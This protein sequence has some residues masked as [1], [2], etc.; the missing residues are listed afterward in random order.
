EGESLMNL[1]AAIFKHTPPPPH[2][3]NPAVSAELSRLTMRLLGKKPGDRPASAAEVRDELRRLRPEADDPTLVARTPA[4]APAPAPV[5]RPPRRRGLVA[6][7]A[8]LLILLPLGYFYGGTVM[9]IVTNKGELVIE[10][11]D[12]NVEVI[13][14]GTNVTVHDKVKDRRL[15]LSAGDYDIDGREEGEGGGRFATKKGRVTRGG[16]ETVV[17]RLELAKAKTPDT[18]TTPVRADGERKAAEW[19]LSLGGKVTIRDGDEDRDINTAK[20]LPAEPQVVRVDLQQ[21]TGVTDA[22]LARL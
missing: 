10:N 18:D 5:H 22:D 13:V 19:V 20:D 21:R 9:R 3:V 16:Q 7:A 4:P 6:V 1:L 17:G 2:E 12:P 11:D 14:K 15:V 8:A